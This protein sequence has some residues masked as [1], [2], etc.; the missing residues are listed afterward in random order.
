MMRM[1]REHLENVFGQVPQVDE[2]VSLQLACTVLMFEVVRADYEKHPAELA[3]IRQHLIKAFDLDEVQAEQ[4][5]Q[6]AIEHAENAISLH[7]FIR[8]INDAY[9]V[10]D[11]SHLLKVLW[12]VAHADGYLDKHE[13]YA[14]RKL[15]DLLYVPHRVFIRS[16]HQSA[17]I[18]H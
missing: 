18:D 5:M 2:Q 9:S 16:K 6:A 3:V 8:A 17:G 12:D 11:K 4:L 15:A 10:Q 1:L 7:E 14:I 13:E